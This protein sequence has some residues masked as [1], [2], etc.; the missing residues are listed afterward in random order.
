MATTPKILPTSSVSELCDWIWEVHYTDTRS[1]E[2]AKSTLKQIRASIGDVKLSEV[3]RDTVR[4]FMADREGDAP[5]SLRRKVAV[6]MKMFNEGF[7]EG[8]MEQVRPP[9]RPRTQKPN[10]ICLPPKVEADVVAG[11]I[12][13]G[14]LYAE[15]AVFLVDTGMRCGEA[16]SLRWDAVIDDFSSATVVRSK[17]GGVR[18]IPLT[19]RSRKLLIKL[20]NNREGPFR[21]VNYHNFWQAWS[22]VRKDLGFDEDKRFTPHALRH[23]FATRLVQR[24]VPLETVKTLM[25]HSR[26]DQTLE[27]AHHAPAQLQDAI[28]VLEN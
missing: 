18:R 13:Q 27:Y 3:T 8:W 24:G 11:L 23:T 25:G 16:L 14:P 19:Q 22:R 2:T 9:P 6:L 17:S 12:E 28:S 1:R 4:R 26:Y 10:H 21:S 7:A 15:L 5:S 20:S